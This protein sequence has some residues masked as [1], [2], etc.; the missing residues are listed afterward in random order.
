MNMI[1]SHINVR[2]CVWVSQ[3]CNLYFNYFTALS[4]WDRWACC[5]W[6]VIQ[7]LD[8]YDYAQM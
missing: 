1:D 5:L 4:E 2:L 6:A 7:Q 8:L 3:E